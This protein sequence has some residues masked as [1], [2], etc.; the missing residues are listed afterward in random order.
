MDS[1]LQEWW[2]SLLRP[3]PYRVFCDKLREFTSREFEKLVSDLFRQLGA[4][5]K[6]SPAGANE[7]ID[8][9]LRFTDGDFMIQCKKWKKRVGEPTVREVYAAAAKHKVKG[10]IIVTTS[11][12][13]IKA[14]EF[15]IDL[16]PP[17]VGLIDGKKLFDLMN[18]HM[19]S[20]VADIQEGIWKS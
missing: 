10:A 15:L 2:R 18:Q 19:P 12:F 4:D 6:I 5:P 20:V 17:P 14:M 3:I 1:D 11:E 9:L 13:T 16:R 7:G 8:I